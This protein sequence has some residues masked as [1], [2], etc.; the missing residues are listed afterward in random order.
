MWGGSHWVSVP[1]VLRHLSHDPSKAPRGQ[2]PA[3]GSGGQPSNASSVWPSLLPCFTPVSP[4]CSW[5]CFSNK[6][7]IWQS[8]PQALLWR[9]S[10]LSFQGPM[11]EDNPPFDKAGV[12]PCPSEVLIPLHSDDF[13]RSMKAHGTRESLRSLAQP[14]GRGY[15]RKVWSQARSARSLCWVGRSLD[16]TMKTHHI[17]G[18]RGGSLLLRCPVQAELSSSLNKGLDEE[19]LTRSSV[20]LNSRTRENK[21]GVGGA[22]Q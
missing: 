9:E 21:A 14:W 2:M 7:P 22:S 13:W 11:A 20:D 19:E 17:G 16:E 8:W 10:R 4:S 3:A 12:I 1:P 6:L 15:K 18:E 5:D